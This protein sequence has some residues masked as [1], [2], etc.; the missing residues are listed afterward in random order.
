VSGAGRRPWFV[1]GGWLLTPVVAWAVA[2]LGG[3]LGAVVGMRI[4]SSTAALAA[5]ALGALL[6]AA[7]AVIGWARVMRRLGSRGSENKDVTCL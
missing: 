3:W 4:R 2:F 1:V 5:I 6:G 7:S